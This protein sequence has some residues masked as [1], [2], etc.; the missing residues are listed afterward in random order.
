MY[1]LLAQH[2][3][4]AHPYAAFHHPA[5]AYGAD[6]RAAG[7]RWLQASLFHRLQQHLTA[8]YIQ[9]IMTA[10]ERHLQATPPCARRGGRHSSTK[11]LQM[12][13]SGLHAQFTQR[14]AG[15]VHERLRPADKG[16]GGSPTGN[17][18]GNGRAARHALF[19][20]QPDAKL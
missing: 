1:F 11:T 12:D 16:V 9:L 8:P 17:H 18:R 14:G 4:A 7:I 3:I 2:L 5:F 15:G 6:A 20:I 10:V 13:A 19:C